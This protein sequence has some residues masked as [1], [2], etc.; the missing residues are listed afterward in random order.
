[1]LIRKISILNFRGIRSLDWRPNDALCF[2][3][4]PGDSGKSTILDAIEAAL[5][6]RWFSFVESDFLRPIPQNPS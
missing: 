4:G 2:I 1:M 5:S 3:I 6:S